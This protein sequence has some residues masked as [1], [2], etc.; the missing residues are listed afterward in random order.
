[1]WVSMGTGNKEQVRGLGC[2]AADTASNMMGSP[3]EQLREDV[4]AQMPT[5]TILMGD[6]R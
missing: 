6:F 4:Q 1:M 2:H 3:V 5:V